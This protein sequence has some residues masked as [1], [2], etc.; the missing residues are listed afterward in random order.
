MWDVEADFLFRIFGKGTKRFDLR[1]QKG[2]PDFLTALRHP[3]K[4]L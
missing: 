2:L 4:L 1:A 3:C